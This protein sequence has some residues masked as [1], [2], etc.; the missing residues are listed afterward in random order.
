MEPQ[1]QTKG[2]NP[3]ENPFGAEGY[4]RLKTSWRQVQPYN[5][6][7]PSI[8]I[9]GGAD[10]RFG[11]KAPVGCV[12]VAMGQIMAYYSWPTQGSYIRNHGFSGKTN[13]LSA[14]LT[15]AR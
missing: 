4:R 12:V 8:G 2:E 15:G 3:W 9:K 6:Y 7:C 14:Y 11:G 13:I 10:E 5:N 1:I